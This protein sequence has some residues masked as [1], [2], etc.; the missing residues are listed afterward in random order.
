MQRSG[1][2]VVAV[3]LAVFA[4]IYLFQQANTD[5]A[6]L[7]PPPSPAT[8]AGEPADLNL[9]SPAPVVPEVANDLGPIEPAAGG[10][11]DTSEPVGGSGPAMHDPDPVA[12]TE[13]P[14][15]AA[16]DPPAGGSSAPSLP[17]V[18][19][20]A[21]PRPVK[22]GHAGT[23]V[24][25]YFQFS[26]TKLDTSRAFGFVLL[27][28]AALTT[29]EKTVQHD[30]C[31]TLL[32]T[33]D[34][35]SPGVAG[36]RADVLAT[37]WPIMASLDEEEIAD[38]FLTRDCDRLIS[39]YDHSLAR[40]LAWKAG[41]SELSGPLLIT[42]P[43]SGD[44]GEQ[45]R[46]P[47]VVDFSKANHERAAKTLR[48]WFRQLKHRPELWTNRIREGTI[49][50]ELADAVN[51]TAGVMLAVMAGKWESVTAVATP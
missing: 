46:D 29:S 14:P 30:F 43:S 50:A 41:V 38:A 1:I 3:F 5:P 51:E 6:L 9:P 44:A 22:F 35:L 16:G 31:A 26:K 45:G 37:Y 48:Y 25:S 24:I 2:V 8:A 12:P 4:A 42:W 36:A 27:P 10:V 20:Y 47:L 7:L 33:L 18:D 28:K 34:F 17:R 40:Q 19:G 13:L 39:W 32:S 11:P 49:R 15:A 21:T 23:K